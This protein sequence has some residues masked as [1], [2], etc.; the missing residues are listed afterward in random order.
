MNSHPWWYLVGLSKEE[1]EEFERLAWAATP[2][3]VGVPDMTQLYWAYWAV[4][5]PAWW[6]PPPKNTLARARWDF[7][8]AVRRLKEDV[9]WYLWTEPWLRF[10]R[11][12]LPHAD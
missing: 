3:G 4:V 11:R 7:D 12:I 5:G 1:G 2:P 10:K 6:E 9:R 8:R